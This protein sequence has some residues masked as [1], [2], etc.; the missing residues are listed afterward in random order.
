MDWSQF[1][2]DGPPSAA[3]LAAESTADEPPLHPP[4]PWAKL[5]KARYICWICTSLP[6]EEAPVGFRPWETTRGPAVTEN[7]LVAITMR[8][9]YDYWP[10][11]NTDGP[12]KPP[13]NYP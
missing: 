12:P 3:T 5:N 11:L 8:K 6:D 1:D 7:G 10:P 9:I 13:V 2:G 4:T